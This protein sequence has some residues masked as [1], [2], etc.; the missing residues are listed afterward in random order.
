MAAA[1]AS[2]GMDIRQQQEMWRSFKRL[3][4]WSAGIIIA[5]LALLAAFVA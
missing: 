3:V 5:V 4:I 1:S 2:G